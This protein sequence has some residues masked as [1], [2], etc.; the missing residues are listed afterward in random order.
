MLKQF[1][2]WSYKKAKI[3][4]LFSLMWLPTLA[5]ADSNSNKITTLLDNIT[6]L[7]TAEIVQYV[8]IVGIVGIGYAWLGMGRMPKEKAIAWCAGIGIILS[9]GW[10]GRQLIPGSM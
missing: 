7:L 5:L 3:I 10:I 6:K 9:A 4:T 2:K 8:G 1:K